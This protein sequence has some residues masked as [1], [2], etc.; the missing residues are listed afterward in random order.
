MSDIFREVEEELQRQK[1]KRIW[2]RY[3]LWVIGGAL[4][5]ILGTVGF[6]GWEAYQA[7]QAADRGDRFLAA[8]ELS[9]EGR[10]DEAAA[11]LEALTQDGGPGYAILSRFRAA[12]DLSIGGDAQAALDAFDAIAADSN[13]DGFLQDIARIRAG[14]IAVDMETADAVRSRIGDLAEADGPLR[15]SAREIL[16]LS[17]WA[18]SDYQAAKTQYDALRSDTEMPTAMRQRVE[19]MQALLA[20]RLDDTEAAAGSAQSSGDTSAETQ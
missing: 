4:A 17:A 3:G 9:E 15:F 16:G 14:Y 20:S 7:S 1:M 11:A 2:D 8:L 10:T 19:L 12:S 6:K 13:V 5:I 18:A